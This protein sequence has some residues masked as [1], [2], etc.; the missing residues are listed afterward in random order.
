MKEKINRPKFLIIYK[1]CTQILMPK[2]L[3]TIDMSIIKISKNYHSI[4]E[5]K[6]LSIHNLKF[7]SW[8]KNS[9]NATKFAYLTST[10]SAGNGAVVAGGNI[11]PQ[12]NRASGGAPIYL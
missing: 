2:I 6:F 4:L 3:T 12:V 11:R 5:E 9:V 1:L 10:T 7:F 8:V